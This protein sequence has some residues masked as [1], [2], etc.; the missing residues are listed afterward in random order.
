MNPRDYLGTYRTLVQSFH[1]DVVSSDTGEDAAS[2]DD[3][4]DS[5]PLQTQL[6]FQ[7]ETYVCLRKPMMVE[8]VKYDK[9]MNCTHI[10]QKSC[11]DV[12]TTQFKPAPVRI[13]Q[14]SRCIL[15]LSSTLR[16]VRILPRGTCRIERAWSRVC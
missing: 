2:D 11:F 8:E 9:H 10:V 15:S 3:G 13:R 1:A 12:F 5:P 14:V 16:T 6:T 4:E 7:N